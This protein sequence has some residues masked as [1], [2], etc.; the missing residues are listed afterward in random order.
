MADVL[1]IQP[2]VE[3][4]ETRYAPLGLLS[5]AAYLEPKY[6]VKIVDERFEPDPKAAIQAEVGKG[7]IIVGVTSLT[8]RQIAHG[9][10]VTRWVKEASRSVPVVWG[11]FHTS[12]FPKEAIAVDGFDFVVAKEGVSTLLELVDRLA[13]G[14]TD[15]FKDIPGLSWK[16]DGVFYVNPER[17]FLNGEK[18][19]TPAW[20]LVDVK[21]YA[22]ALAPY[23]G[24]PAV[25][26]TT[27]RGCPFRCK[28]C[29]EL[30]FNNRT[31]RPRNADQ[32]VRE[33]TM[34]HKEY[35]IEFINIHDDLYIVNRKSRERALYIG[36]RLKEEGVKIEY[37]VTHRVDMFEPGFLKE[38]MSLGLRQVRAG[39][40]SG[41]PRILKAIAKDITREQ[42]IE[43]ARVSAKLGLGIYYS[44]VIGWPDETEA[45]RRQTIDLAL[46]LIRINPKARIYPLWIY[47]PYP[48]TPHFDEAAKHGFVMPKTME[49]WSG[50]TWGHVN[51]PWIEE[52]ERFENLHYL[53]RL[54]FFNRPIRDIISS[55]SR[56]PWKLTAQR[57]GGV[58]SRPWAQWRLRCGGG[59]MPVE[60]RL[61][62]PVL[63]E[64]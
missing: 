41:S 25:D 43:S 29:Y 50:Y 6:S 44:F 24:A 8:G 57:V 22:K 19:P 32:V 42:I 35:G 14:K 27:S 26:I 1:L 53:S 45:D 37:T 4:Q 34:L 10:E 11:G 13:A 21:Q 38:M 17:V 47:V 2:I 56:S 36:R 59:P 62:R 61:L 55:T 63:G 58:L 12:Y 15:S 31:W 3:K 48:G 51:V 49:E 54:A 52:P 20:H 28:F 40:E 18:L 46:N 64:A 30:S 5:L 16:R 7:P 33:I 60:H 39:V 23:F 9:L